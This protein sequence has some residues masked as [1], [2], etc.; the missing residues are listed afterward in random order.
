MCSGRTT[1]KEFRL[2]ASDP[3]CRPAIWPRLATCTCAMAH[4]RASNCFRLL[5]SKRL[6]TPPW[7]CMPVLNPISGTRI[8]S[9]LCPTSESIL[10]TG[11][12]GQMIM[13]L[14]DLDVLAVTTA[15]ENHNFGEFASSIYNAVNADSSLPADATNAKLLAEAILDV[16]T[17]KPTMVAAIPNIATTISGKVYHFPPNKI[18]VKSLSLVV[19][20]S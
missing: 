17:Q 3:I 9:G 19:A 20:D 6:I 10:A 12:N 8:V 13:I 15:R 5:G 11:F 4:G 2:G 1:P 7:T 14:P 16:S 18:G